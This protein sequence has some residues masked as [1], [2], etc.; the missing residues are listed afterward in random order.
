M[1]KYIKS[2][3][4]IN[5]HYKISGTKPTAIVFIHGWLGNANWWNN[6]Q[7]YFKDNYTVV[8]IDLPG[9][10][11]SEAG[12]VDWSSIQY[13]K[14]IKVVVDQISSENVI[15]VGHSMSGPYTL[16]AA[17]LIAKVKL[18]VLVDTLKDMDQLMDYQQADE[19][20]FKSYKKDFK[21]AVE[22]ILPKF[23]FAE[24]T[25]TEIREQLKSEFLKNDAEFA[26]ESLEPL[27]KMDI[28]HS[29]KQVQVPV[30]A[31]NSNYTPTNVDSIRKY[32]KD[33]EYKNIS[34]SGHYPMLEKPDEFN[35]SLNEILQKVSL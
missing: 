4:G 25:P 32:I 31:L 13:A 22:N 1:E 5:I 35:I 26:I 10:G 27:Y 11:K 7:E 18:V 2:E 16:E 34:G 20:I 12:R 30:R 8:Q 24:S 29:S 21:Y 14:D 15:L 3:D 19:L 6:Q 23:L 17:L 33:F 28:R 9:H